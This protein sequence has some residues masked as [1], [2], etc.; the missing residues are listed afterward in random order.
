MPHKV[1]QNP[2]RTVFK[3]SAKNLGG[4]GGGCTNPLPCPGEGYEYLFWLIW[5]LIT[6]FHLEC[7]S[8]TPRDIE[9]LQNGVEP[10]PPQ[11]SIP[12]FHGSLMVSLAC[13]DSEV[14]TSSYGAP[15]ARPSST[16]AVD[17]TGDIGRHVQVVA[18][19]PPPETAHLTHRPAVSRSCSIERGGAVED[20]AHRIEQQPWVPRTIV[21]W[22]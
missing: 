1:L 6:S 9:I 20:N 19:S 4:G 5:P 15:C 22:L 8:K 3:L 18:A 12:G 16:A 10:A 14:S 7:I 13:I 11:I 17:G 21:T 2:A